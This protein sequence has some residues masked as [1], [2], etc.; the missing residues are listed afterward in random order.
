MHRSRGFVFVNKM[1]YYL[2]AQAVLAS[3]R[4]RDCGR[5]GD[6]AVLVVPTGS[7]AGLHKEDDQHGRG[8]RQPDPPDDDFFHR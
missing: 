5:S 1:L 3:P 8:Q 6:L 7:R 2:H 4:R